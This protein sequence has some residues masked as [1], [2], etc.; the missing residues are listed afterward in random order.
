MA[1]EWFETWFDTAAYHQL[2]KNRDEIEASY[3]I[4]NLVEYL[5]PIKSASFLDIACGKGRHA[6]QIHEK[7][8]KVDGYDLS[9]NSILKAKE[10]EKDGLSFYRHDMRQFFRI[11]YYDFALNLFTSFGYFQT[12]RDEHLAMRSNLKN[13]KPEGTLVIDFLNREKVIANL[14]PHEVKSIDGVDFEISKHIEN[15]QVVKK[16]QFSNNGSAQNYEEKVNLLG[17][18][19]F[20]KYV[21]KE[22]CKIKQVFGDY[23]LNPFDEK[24]SDRLIMIV[25][26]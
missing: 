22:G 16:I 14:V 17:L 4:N 2:Y 9:E 7:G 26:K 11:N 8:F 23:G 24:T 3:F 10:L 19:D 20:N 21:E 6:A 5:Q 15:N 13:L 25:A 18:S 12:E 1:K